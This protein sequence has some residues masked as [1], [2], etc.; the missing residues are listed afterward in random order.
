[1]INLIFLLLFASPLREVV[2]VELS[3]PTQQHHIFYNYVNDNF[4]QKIFTRSLDEITIEIENCNYFELNLNF[5]IV[6]QWK[7]IYSMP[8]E[9]EKV[10]RYLL[11]ESNTFR[12]YFQ[13]LSDYLKANITYSEDNLPQDA[14][15]VLL[16]RKAS[17]VGYSNFVSLLLDA[18]GIKNRMVRGF[19]LKNFDLGNGS[20]KVKTKTLIPIP[21][22]WIEIFLANGAKI[23]YDPQFQKFSANYLTAR[24]DIKFNEVNKFTV[25]VNKI[26]KKILSK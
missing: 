1:M 2:Q 15:S 24:Q 4:S 3:I 12:S 5:R 7:I 23:F 22:R 11:E 6:P 17:C 20:T 9:I 16:N 13:N 25:K 21:H 14:L 8:P 10:V 26:S 19:Y 18:A